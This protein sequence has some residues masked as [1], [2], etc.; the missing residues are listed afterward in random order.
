[1]KAYLV[2]D[3]AIE[4]LDLFFEYAAQIPKQIQKHHGRY[5]VKGVVPEKIEGDWLPERLVILEFDSKQHA[6]NFLHDPE[7]KNLFKIRK[8][9]T[10]SNLILAEGC[11]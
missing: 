2:L 10:Q 5:I 8:S 7:T 11:H 6:Q 4:N 3:L 1:M 9:A